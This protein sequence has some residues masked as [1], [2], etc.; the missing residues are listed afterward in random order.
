MLLDHGVETGELLVLV[1]GVYG[2]LLDQ[3]IQVSIA[4]FCHVRQPTEM[5]QLREE[6]LNAYL[7][8]RLR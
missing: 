1:V 5:L 2:S 6:A 8:M 4:W 3:S 7:L